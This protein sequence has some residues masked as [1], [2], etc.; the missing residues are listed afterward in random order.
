M[1]SAILALVGRM[2]PFSA[3]SPSEARNL[4]AQAR[5]RKVAEG[6]RVF[7]QG[8]PAIR[9][10]LLAEGELKIVQT[11]PDGQQIIAHWVASG[12][13]FGLAVAMGKDEY[14][15]SAIAA[16][17]STVLAWPSAVWMDLVSSQPAVA[18]SALQMMGSHL[19]EAFTRLREVATARVEQRIAGALL[20]LVRQVGRRTEQGV[21]IEFPITRQDIAEM[22]ST[23]IFTVSRVL[24][25]WEKAGV[26][27]GGRRRIV[28]LD[29]QALVRLGGE[30]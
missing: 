21:Q 12:Q 13:F 19:Q 7:D 6:A 9:F 4:L 25:A 17:A 14:P 18:R 28:I 16:A 20:R 3:L 1:H 2:D 10:F 29:P 24:S 11:T 30:A 22:T 15:G 23:T 27:T 5:I 8:A 26:L